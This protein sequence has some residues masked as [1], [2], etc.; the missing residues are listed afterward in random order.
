[1]MVVVRKSHGDAE[2]WSVRGLA[3]NPHA[4]VS[5]LLFDYGGEGVLGDLD[6]AVH[7]FLIDLG[8]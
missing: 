3:F 6:V 7:S 2:A 4:S 1:L 5:K 8:L